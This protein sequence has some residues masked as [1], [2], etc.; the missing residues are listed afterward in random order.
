MAVVTALPSRGRTY[1]VQWTLITFV[2]L[3]TQPCTLLVYSR[4][5][6]MACCFQKH[7][8]NL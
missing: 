6:P 5:I 7:F 4:S 2:C 3:T 8:V 1:S